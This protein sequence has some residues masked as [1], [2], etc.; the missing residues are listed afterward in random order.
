MALLLIFQE[1]FNIYSEIL[2]ANLLL[3]CERANHLIIQA[4]YQPQVRNS[5]LFC[6]DS[7]YL[8]ISLENLI[9]EPQYVLSL[10]I[11]FLEYFMQLILIDK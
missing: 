7:L 10:M 9:Y 4:K 2:V 8:L 11:Y 1:K 5:L 3:W 6:L